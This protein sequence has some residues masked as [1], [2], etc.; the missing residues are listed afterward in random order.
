M[1]QTNDLKEMTQIFALPCAHGPSR[2]A[3]SMLPYVREAN[4]RTTGWINICLGSPGF[5]VKTTIGGKR[6][7]EPRSPATKFYNSLLA[8]LIKGYHARMARRAQ[9]LRC[10]LC[11]RSER[12]DNKLDKLRE[13]SK[14]L[15]ATDHA[16]CGHGNITRPARSMCSRIS[17]KG[18]GP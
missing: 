2:A 7:K 13:A 12:A 16:P 17:I 8:D 10:S 3:S 5:V 9:H 6:R 4:E 14:I 18:A 11:E 15:R 1:E